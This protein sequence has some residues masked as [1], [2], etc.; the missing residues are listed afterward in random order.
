MLF[1]ELLFLKIFLFRFGVQKFFC[2]L[3][4]SSSVS[5][6]VVGDYL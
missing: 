4:Y 5:F 6:K 3:N 1:E 2:L